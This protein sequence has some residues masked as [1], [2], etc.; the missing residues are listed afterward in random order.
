MDGETS[1]DAAPPAA[2]QVESTPVTTS[3]PAHGAD[4]AIAAAIKASASQ[5]A[6]AQPTEETPSEPQAEQKTAD[7]E[8]QKDEKAQ[9]EAKPNGEAVKPDSESDKGPIPYARF[10]EVNTAK[11]AAEAQVAQY[12]PLAR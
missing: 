11:N 9:V 5:A 4:A 8:T 10:A 12:E 1:T 2:P 3:A 6:P 7:A